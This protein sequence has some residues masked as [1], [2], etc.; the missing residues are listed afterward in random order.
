MTQLCKIFE[1][2]QGLYFF[3]SGVMVRQFE[4][5][6]S[7]YKAGDEIA[8][9]QPW[10]QDI[11]GVGKDKNCGRGVYLETWDPEWEARRAAKLFRVP[12]PY[13]AVVMPRVVKA[14]QV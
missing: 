2:K 8:A 13:G 1:D 6:Q 9:H 12:H 10:G 7:R 14:K 3:L 5:D 11:V 4:G